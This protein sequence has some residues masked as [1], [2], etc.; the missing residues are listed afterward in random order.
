MALPVKVI[1][2]TAGP[3][4]TIYI[5]QQWLRIHQVMCSFQWSFAPS[6]YVISRAVFCHQFPEVCTAL[7][8]VASGQTLVYRGREQTRTH[9]WRGEATCRKI[10]SGAIIQ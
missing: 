8:H 4:T 2:W 10:V 6:S 5:S 7:L 1:V 9:N 3:E